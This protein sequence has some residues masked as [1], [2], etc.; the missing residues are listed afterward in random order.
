MVTITPVAFA[1]IP[2]SN[3]QDGFW[4]FFLDNISYTRPDNEPCTSGPAKVP[5]I[6]SINPLSSPIGSQDLQIT[7]T[8]S[9]FGN[10]PTVNLP[11]GIALKSQKASDTQIVIT[12]TLTTSATTGPN[13]ITVSANGS[14]SNAA[15]LNIL[16]PTVSCVSP[17]TRGQSTTCQVS[18]G[19]A[20]ATYEWKFNDANNNVVKAN[21]SNT[22]WPGIMVTSGTVAVTVNAAGGAISLAPSY[23]TV[24]DRTDFAFAAV[25]PA[26][27]EGNSITCYG[28]AGP[29]VLPSPPTAGSAEGWSCADMAYT[30]NPTQ[31]SDGGPNNGY[32][33]VASVS[34]AFGGQPTKFEYIVVSDL[35]NSASDFYKSQCGTYSNSNSGGFIAGSQLSQ[36]VFNHEQGSVLSHWTEY[37]DAQN[38]PANNIG[39]IL[40][41][42]VGAPGAFDF[43]GSLDKAAR[44]AL[45]RI[46]NAVAVEPCTGVV[47]YDSSQTCKYCGTINYVPYQSCGSSTPIPYCQ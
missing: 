38:D 12:A 5:I 41:Q 18:N 45:N 40:E 46:A 16:M 17:V 28:D 36:N 7:L 43:V 14:T 32:W 15:F 24:P 34:D 6:Y 11:S 35:L 37:R 20:G 23:I 42:M 4:D 1:G 30:P 19:P 9:G 29:H 10:K 2:V 33:Y 39:V 26:K 47:V 44:A 13:P 3:Y 21:N 27:I 8:G 22:A 25:S 31:V